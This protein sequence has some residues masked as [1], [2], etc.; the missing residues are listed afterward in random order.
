MDAHDRLSSRRL[1]DYRLAAEM[2]AKDV[3][4][5]QEQ[6]AQVQKNTPTIP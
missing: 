6:L 3:G 4:R 2:T 1:T 5:L